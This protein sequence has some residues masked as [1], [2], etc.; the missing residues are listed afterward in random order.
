MGLQ[1]EATF[2]QQHFHHPL[3]AQ[4]DQ[5][6]FS[7]LSNFLL[8]RENFLIDF[9]RNKFVNISIIWIYIPAY[10]NF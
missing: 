4:K 3:K 5:H 6:L 7:Y 8:L 9:V 1:I 10:V 2:L